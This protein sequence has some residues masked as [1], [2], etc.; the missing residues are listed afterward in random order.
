[1]DIKK[2][3]E[4]AQ[5]LFE[6]IRPVCERI[7]IVGSVK[8]ADK[9]DCH[10]I[11]ILLIPV[12]GHPR[13]EFGD[14]TIYKTHLDKRLSE[15]HREG[16]LGHPQTKA[17][18][19]KLKKRAI[20]NCGEINEFKLELYIVRH[21]T[22]AVQNVI[23]TGPSLFSHRFVTNKSNF[24]WI[25]ETNQRIPGLLPDEY[26][27]VRGETVIKLNGKIL[28]LKEE[29]DAIELLGMGWIP[30]AERRNIALSW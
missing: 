6:R 23:R 12:P 27:Y 19:D 17:D 29:G 24:I 10:D 22:W 16:I 30:P 4:I 5:D 20:L 2:A 13:P 3:T 11:E 15:L 26:E 8:R 1:M 25:R 21:D 18:G 7:E 14:K 28:E 9:P